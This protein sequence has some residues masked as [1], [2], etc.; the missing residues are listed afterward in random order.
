MNRIK[1][2]RDNLNKNLV[3]AN[4]A[5]TIMTNDD[6]RLSEINFDYDSL[7]LANEDKEKL[8]AYEKELL[9][10][11]KRLGEV[12]YN[13]GLNLELARNLF[14][15]YSDR[16][17][18]GDDPES[19]RYWYTALGL[20]KDQVYL[21]S[22]RYKL[23]LE[24]PNKKDRLIQLSDRA[25][26]ET[27]NKKTPDEIRLKVFEGDLTTGKE[28]SDARKLLLGHSKITKDRHQIKIN[29]IKIM[30]DN[31]AL[32]KNE[33]EDLLELLVNAGMRY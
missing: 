19:F 9:F 6:L 30:M 2:K 15:K 26:K 1:R 3:A 17:K 29:L 12:A 24:Y 4:E 7:G 22:A 5:V 23:C 10:Q 32:D 14:K 25:I 27:V 31:T 18:D 20:N 11:G 13:V 8:I 21:F 16:N 33:A 28:I